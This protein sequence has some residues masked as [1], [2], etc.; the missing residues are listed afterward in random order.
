MND[1]GQRVI[2]A[3]MESL[4]WAVLHSFWQIGVIALLYALMLALTK[5]LPNARRAKLRYF[6]GCATLLTMTAVPM[7]AFYW[8]SPNTRLDSYVLSVPAAS[9][10]LPQSGVMPSPPTL[11]FD[12]DIVETVQ[13]QAT[14]RV[15]SNQPGNRIMWIAAAW[16]IGVMVAA[17]R[18]L[19][20]LGRVWQLKHTACEQPDLEAIV[21]KLA[22]QLGIRRAV[23]C[24]GTTL[25]KVPLLIGHLRPVIL[26]PLSLASGLEP[27]QLECLLA[28]ELAH[29]RRHDYMVNLLQVVIETL[30]F[31]HPLMW[32]VSHRVRVDR[33]YCTD[34]LALSITGQRKNYVEALLELENRRQHALPAVAA[35]GGS[36]LGRVQ[37]LVATSSSNTSAGMGVWLP[38]V[39]VAILA[40]A[41][42]ASQHSLSSLRAS[43]T[44]MTSSKGDNA[45]NSEKMQQPDL[46]KTDEV[47]PWAWGRGNDVWAMFVAATE[48]D[49]AKLEQLV[50]K[51]PDL[52]RCYFDYCTPLHYAAKANQLEA[53]QWLLDHGAD[54][55]SYHS[56]ESLIS[57]LDQAA[58]RGYHKMTQLLATHLQK[59]F[60]ISS[61]GD[62]I[63]QAM[64][65]RDVPRTKALI[66]QH[67]VDVADRR[68]NKPL[69]WA[70]MTR[71]VPLIDWLLTEGADI[72]AMR[73]DGARPLDLTNGDYWYRGW[74]DL[75]P[76]APQD[77]WPLID[78][79]IDRG[80]DYDITTACRVGDINRVREL[81][82]DDPQLA[83]ADVPY[84]T[85][86]SG[87]PLRSAA[88]A[89]CLDIVRLLLEHGAD[90]NK[91]E[92]G[93]APWGGA[94]YDA[95]QNNHTEVARLLLEHSANPNQEVESSANVLYVADHAGVDPE[96]RQLLVDAGAREFLPDD[97]VEERSRIADSTAPRKTSEVN[98]LADLVRA[99]READAAAVSRIVKT[100]PSLVNEP[101][102]AYWAKGERTTLLHLV[103]PGDGYKQLPAHVE[104]A[105]ILLDEGAKVD[106]LGN[107]P[108]LGTCTPIT[109]AAWGGHAELIKLLLE[110][111]AAPDGAEVTLPQHKPLRAASRHGHRE[112]VEAL[113][114]AGANYEFFDLLAAGLEK[115][116]ITHLEAEPESLRQPLSDGSSVLHAALETKTG[117]A[118]VP[119]LLERGGDPAMQDANGRSPL[120]LAI[121]T[122]QQGAINALKDVSQPFDIFA[123]AGLGDSRAVSVLL[124][125]HPEHAV[126]AQLDGTTPLFYAVHGGSVE[127]VRGLLAAGAEA[128][129]R[130]NRF[131]ACPTPLQ[132]A[133]Q[134]QHQD[135]MQLLLTS[136]AE[137]NVTPSPDHYQPTPLHAAARWGN[138]EQVKLLLDHGATISEG[139]LGWVLY[140]GK[141]DILQLLFERDL[142]LND[143]AH[144]FAL[145][146][147]ARSGNVKIVQLLLKHGAD[148]T[149]KD[150]DGR[151]PREIALANGRIEVAELLQA[152]RRPADSTPM[153]TF[154]QAV[155]D[156][157]L[158]TVKQM[159]AQDASLANRDCRPINKQDHHTEGLPLVQ[160]CQD[161]HY[162]I[163]KLLLDH[164]AD[165]DAPSPTG[166]LHQYGAPIFNAF[167]NRNYDLVKLLLERGASVDTHPHGAACLMDSA[168]RRATE[169]GKK[170]AA[171]IAQT[172]RRS[173]DG[174]LLPEESQKR[175]PE[176]S[177]DALADAPESVQLLARFVSLGGQP[178][179]WE[180][181]RRQQQDLIN[182]FLRIRPDA[183]SGKFD[184]L[185][186]SLH[187]ETVFVN[188]CGAAGWG[189]YP[190]LLIQCM[191]T[192]PHLYHS[193]LAKR[194]IHYA[195]QS[196]NRDG[197]F[198]D[199]RRLIG[200]QLEYLKQHDAVT[201]SFSSGEPFVPLHLLAERFI[202]LKHW[203]CRCQR[204]STE[205]DLINLAQL[206]VEYGFDVNA[207]HPETNLTPLEMAKAN[208]RLKG[209]Y[210]EWLVG[211]GAISP[212][213]SSGD[214]TVAT[215]FWK[216]IEMSDLS[217]VKKM[218]DKD[219]SLAVRDFRPI[220][221]QNPHPDGFPLMKACQEGNYDLAKL[222]LEHGADPDAIC[223]TEEQRVFGG[224]LFISVYDEDE[225]KPRYDIANLML[226]HGASVDAYPWCHEPMVY[227][228]YGAAMRAAPDF[229]PKMVH[230][231]VQKYLPD[232]E[233]D[234]P[235]LSEDAPEAVKLFDR[236]LSIGI[237]LPLN[238]VIKHEHYEL[239]E[240]MLRHDP[241]LCLDQLRGAASWY[242]YPKVWDLIMEICPDLHSCESAREAIH[243]ATKSHNRDGSYADYRR[244]IEMQLI[245][246]QEQGELE[247]LRTGDS[248]YK[249]HHWLAK[250]F[251]WHNNYGYKASVS[252]PE[253]LLDL[254]E[255]YI[256]YGFDDF[257]CRDPETNRTPLAT[258]IARGTHPGMLEYADFLIQHGADLCRNEPEETN[259]LALAK[260]I[261]E[262]EHGEQRKAFIKLL[263]RPAEE[264]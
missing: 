164:E 6:A 102:G 135:V 194:A 238:S 235:S 167:E 3:W 226:D 30:L 94:L 75:H 103:M 38:V 37:R 134:R 175:T 118:L 192:H 110:H 251:C 261:D 237:E 69:H 121:E 215:A 202:K 120:H 105:R 247:E 256:S 154:W 44:S 107:S 180:V 52:I 62:E 50:A 73:P 87:L 41:L 32:L 196:Q 201:T 116:V 229:V 170:Y 74:R 204:L 187:G 166:D 231:G 123:A 199:Y 91:P 46:L 7:T 219:S 68:G 254:A 115:R 28:H 182:D 193:D 126:E 218:L 217:T 172:I 176:V 158:A 211:N 183:P 250:N 4:G 42:L 249:A 9:K 197:E 20:G 86:Y 212:D 155:V 10:G 57:P 136:G 54:A 61:A 205:D 24:V 71:Q 203:N 31:F 18:P 230:R 129:P 259:P 128:S 130:S 240:E 127:I 152:R 90:P 208:D 35:S 39:L 262:S 143:P 148:P 22:Q 191:E 244:L 109:V 150:N 255:L 161:G 188:L 76:D 151:R 100:S 246:L 95:V 27:H 79:L 171:E 124:K 236:V 5:Q 122:G 213:K 228:L 101:I 233:R 104:I 21:E 8:L 242:G 93:L 209:Q 89:G 16:M 29:V 84:S 14:L 207:R 157:D 140:S 1:S 23:Q 106:A 185:G 146:A 184:V 169:E 139:V 206:F 234:Y 163:V 92:H 221:K 200:S 85:W 60:G 145:H 245:Y 177:V 63:A 45:M 141:L 156:G 159:L 119:M 131:W 26:M 53:A 153:P 260:R 186:S 258:A 15:P 13:P 113:I 232:G 198:A 216:A 97:Q 67:G 144:R 77:H 257:N 138:V 17:M 83:N 165:I 72:N 33:E 181:V 214:S 99:V 43:D 224:P 225:R 263:T 241:Q 125:E 78:H 189:G 220:E 264:N 147:A 111:G 142:N 11:D 82:Q 117:A 58:S 19:V 56:P 114:Q 49:V 2:T 168:L 243:A 12:A 210:V 48:G 149:I 239:I 132:L 195:L 70:V 227:W 80:A 47:F 112:A 88:K 137:V 248:A 252:K 51:D 40:T 253:H 222:L 96:L 55:T 173:F 36:L 66:A 178:T 64:R 133:I 174:Y 179:Y 190:D 98:L 223:P 81:L 160:A 162:E 108:N 34:D 65:E 59:K 25:T